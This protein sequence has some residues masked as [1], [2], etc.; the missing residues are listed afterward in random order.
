MMKPDLVVLPH[1]GMAWLHRLDGEAAPETLVCLGARAPYCCAPV[2]DSVLLICNQEGKRISGWRLL[3]SAPWVESLFSPLNLPHRCLAHAVLAYQGHLYVGGSQDHGSALWTMPL[4]HGTQLRTVDLPES[5]RVR[6]KSIDGFGLHAGRLMAVDDM[7]L[8]KYNLVFD[9]TDAGNPVLVATL[10]L[11]PHTTY[12][13]VVD[14]LQ[15]PAGIA[16]L[17]HCINYGNDSWHLSVIDAGTGE[18][19]GNLALP[20][21]Q[22]G[23]SPRLGNHGDRLFVACG[24]HG[25]MGIGIEPFDE[26]SSPG[27]NRSA[28]LAGRSLFEVAERG[29]A[30]PLALS[31]HGPT[32]IKGLAEIHDFAASTGTP[33]RLF[34]VGVDRAGRHGF[35]RLDPDSSLREQVREEV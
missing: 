6:D 35:A 30:C 9:L 34:A 23:D 33:S 10:D 17:S 7:V 18:E 20:Q 5:Q 3:D 19:L 31:V 8:P 24:A 28:W 12:E 2:A 27:Q 4:V 25:M 21:E 16:L 14:C 1:D 22:L 29:G 13:R 32:K 11:P 15:I 26:A